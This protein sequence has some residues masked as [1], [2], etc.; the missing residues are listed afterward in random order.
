MQTLRNLAGIPGRATG[1]FIAHTVGQVNTHSKPMMVTI[2]QALASAR[3]LERNVKGGVL[4]KSPEELNQQ[5]HFLDPTRLS[6]IEKHLKPQDVKRLGPIVQ[7]LTELSAFVR[8]LLQDISSHRNPTA[9]DKARFAQGRQAI[10]ANLHS[11]TGEVAPEQP[12]YSH[13]HLPLIQQL[14]ELGKLSSGQITQARLNLEEQFAG[15]TANMRDQA[16][17]A[18]TDICPIA[19]GLLSRA[20]T[21]PIVTAPTVAPAPIAGAGAAAAGDPTVA[22]RGGEPI[23]IPMDKPS[24]IGALFDRMQQMIVSGPTKA[25]AGAIAYLLNLVDS[26][27]GSHIMVSDPQR[28]GEFSQF[29]QGAIGQINAFAANPNAGAGQLVNLWN[30]L[31]DTLQGKYRLV[32]EGLIRL[33]LLPNAPAEMPASTLETINETLRPEKA[34]AKNLME[35]RE[36]TERDRK[37]MQEDMTLLGEYEMFMKFA[38][39]IPDFSEIQLAATKRMLAA[40]ETRTSLG[41]G[42]EARHRQVVETIERERGVYGLRFDTI[43]EK[44]NALPEGANR[45]HTLRSL[46]KDANK[47]RTDRSKF[48]RWFSVVLFSVFRPIISFFTKM[49]TKRIVNHVHDQVAKLNTGALSVPTSHFTNASQTMHFMLKCAKEFAAGVGPDGKPISHTRLKDYMEMRMDGRCP[50][51]KISGKAVD[52]YM[53]DLSM[54]TPINNASQTM[55]NWIKK[56]PVG[57][58]IVKGFIAAL[59]IAILSLVNYIFVW[60]TNKIASLIARRVTKNIL[61]RSSTFEKLGN[62]TGDFTKETRVKT[63]IAKILADKTHDLLKSIEENG[64]SLKIDR[65]GGSAQTAEEGEAIRAFVKD[66]IALSKVATKVHPTDVKSALGGGIPG[67]QV[68]DDLRMGEIVKGLQGV[69]YD[70]MHIL[71][72]P[73][74]AE[75]L[76]SSI[77]REASRA[78]RNGGKA[79]TEEENTRLRQE[80][81]MYETNQAADQQKLIRHVTRTAVKKTLTKIGF[82]DSNKTSEEYV[83]WLKAT[84]LESNQP[85][86]PA[87]PAPGGSVTPPNVPAIAA[88]GLIPDWRELANAYA[89][90]AK[91]EILESLRTSIQGFITDWRR[92]QDNDSQTTRLPETQALIDAIHQLSEEVSRLNKGEGDISAIQRILVPGGL[93]ETAQ[94]NLRPVTDVEVSIAPKEA[95]IEAVNSFMFTLTN[96]TLT[97]IMAMFKRPEYAK[98]LI[99]TVVGPYFGVEMDLKRS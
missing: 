91:P 56:G 27:I 28:A 81:E 97:E 58:N 35:L 52:R 80:R 7:K 37:L 65:P 34:P 82:I 48:R 68:L 25:A 60:P 36:E 4:A 41:D 30:N 23:L 94:Q 9:E 95:V 83:S 33:P 14:Y 39:G 67:Q 54:T 99:E 13:H 89:A 29:I 24:T 49:F 44:V 75:K 74:E 55:I 16:I 10:L 76:T 63:A 78:I 87:T 20:T 77:L 88:T 5:L 51:N 92:R 3:A 86:P 71:I 79:L 64:G 22:P 17:D 15:M 21:Q 11:P 57:V 73:E 26:S 62:L 93:V 32:F 50:Y 84:L 98:R 42:Y 85:T 96:K 19:K 53:G 12:D 47:K 8:G 46:L 45:I 38:G 61:T 2:A 69:L 43:M 59:P 90:D 18:I 6:Q 40:G 31:T 1:N 66:A 72:K 70:L